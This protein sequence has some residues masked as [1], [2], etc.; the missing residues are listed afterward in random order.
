MKYLKPTGMSLFIDLSVLSTES[1]DQIAISRSYDLVSSYT[2]KLSSGLYIDF[3]MIRIATSDDPLGIA[4]SSSESSPMYV[5]KVITDDNPNT[6]YYF[7]S[8]LL[9]FGL[10]IAVLVSLALSNLILCIY[11]L[12]C[13]LQLYWSGVKVDIGT[14][15]NVMYYIIFSY[16]Y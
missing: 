4:L 16:I 12:K 5:N 6:M 14:R 9:L 2:G 1:L 11:T 7:R 10:I 8:H 15:L 13:V 3:D